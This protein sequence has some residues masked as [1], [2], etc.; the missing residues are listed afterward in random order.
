MTL[1]RVHWESTLSGKTGM[2]EPM[3]R[4]LAE[5]RARYAALAHPAIRYWVEPD[6]T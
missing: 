6:R 4:D 2:S 5:F 3:T 1:Y